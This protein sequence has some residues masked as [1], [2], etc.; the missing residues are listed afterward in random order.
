MAPHNV[1]VLQSQQTQLT[2]VACPRRQ[3]VKGPAIGKRPVHE[4]GVPSMQLAA[5]VLSSPGEHVD[6][7]LL[8]ARAPFKALLVHDTNG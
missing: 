1:V 7:Q 4:A 8:E 2:P 6:Q 3:R 5:A